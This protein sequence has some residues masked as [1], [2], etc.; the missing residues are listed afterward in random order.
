MPKSKRPL[1]AITAGGTGGHMF[2]AQALARTLLE[3]GWRVALLTD[4]RG[5]G[6]GPDLPEVETYRLSA[7]AVLG[8]SPPKKLWALLQ[9]LRGM[10][11]ARRLLRRLG[12][13][14]VVGFGGYAS[15]PAVWAGAGLKLKTVI[16]E[17]NAV[18]GR[19]NRVLAGRAGAIATSF[20][21]V[22]GLPERDLPKCVVTGNP[23]RAAIAEI[24][25]RPYAV[26]GP[27]DRLTLLVTGG[28]QGARVF[29][30]L[31]PAAVCSLPDALKQ[32]LCVVQQVR[33]T[34]LAEVERTYAACGVEAVLKPFFED[35]PQ[36]LAQATLLLCRAGASTVTELAAA[37]RPALLVPY[38][39]AADDHQRANAEAFAAA[40]GGWVLPQSG[41]DA[42]TLAAELRRL[43]EAPA[44]LVRAAGAARGFAEDDAAAHLADLVEGRIHSNGTP[45]SRKEVAA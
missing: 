39:F 2:P 35:L 10:V 27:K 6:F 36:R 32:R 11:Q 5:Q 29:N 23:V 3:R 34:D 12:A 19:A 13:V 9:L 43:F 24:G 30:E 18:A 8:T 20:R 15:L 25:R 26:P 44:T 45:D 38:P 31:V 40:G 14:A 7:N 17:Q 41:L 1:I 33:G 22:R 21:E 16:H 37:G 42:A 4:R 28:S